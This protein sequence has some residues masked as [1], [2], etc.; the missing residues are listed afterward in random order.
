MIPLMKPKVVWQAASVRA[1]SA[2][3]A[4]KAVAKAVVRQQPIFASEA[5]IASRLEICRGCEFWKDGA[6]FGMCNKC[7]CSSMKLNL[8]PLFCPIKKWGPEV[9]NG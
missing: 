7:G 1:A 6:I 4:A 8:A 5:T 3:Q 2:A 9:A